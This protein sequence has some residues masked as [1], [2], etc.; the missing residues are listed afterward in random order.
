MTKSF[1][2]LFKKL[3]QNRKIKDGIIT[4]GT[5]INIEK[6]N[7]IIDADLKSESS[8]SIEE[9]KN[10]K[11]Q[12][13]IKISDT[14]DVY[15]EAIE[16]GLGNTILSREKAKKHEAWLIL[17]KSYLNSL[18][19]NGVIIGKVK[20]GFTVNLNNIKAFLPGS[21][22]DIRPIK[23][24]INLEGKELEFKIIKLDKK[25]NNIVISRKAVILN[26]NNN[27]REKLIEN[28]YE[29][30]II[31]G[32]V[33]NITDYG[34]FIDL[35]GLDGLLHITDMA[36]KR[37]KNPRDLLNIGDDIKVKI[38]KF[39]KEKTRVSLGLKQ[40]T[41]D[42][43]TNID[44]K[45]PVNKKIQG[46]ITNLTDYG[47]FIEIEEGIEGLAHISE[48][49]WINKNVN[50]YKI[51]NIEQ[52][53]E[54]II[55][56][57]DKEKRRISLGMKQCT[58]NPWKIFSSKYKKGDKISGKIKSITDF[59]IFLGLKENIDGLVHCTDITWNT[60]NINEQKK[61]YKKGDIIEVSLLQIDIN[62][63][64]ISLGI[65]QLT[66]D[67]LNKFIILNKKKNIFKVKVTEINNNIIKVNLNKNVD[68]EIKISDETNKTNLKYLKKIKVNNFIETKILNVDKKKRIVNLLPVYKENIINKNIKK[69]SLNK[70]NQNC[71]NTMIEAF[72]KAKPE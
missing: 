14:I 70:K 37:I 21:L 28:I 17:E 40:L 19:I 41:K 7:V 30:Y 3:I 48:I 20:G 31:N 62:K 57:I 64:R 38:I 13:E 44:I 68:G 22:V 24:S 39:D 67:P 6:N 23:E 9:F 65:K 1:K 4:K 8:I 53:V 43:W 52:N 16:D 35:G 27:E 29:G 58:P 51:F 5:I 59:G 11:G 55:L 33:K 63:E 47:C 12:L 42:P 46:K 66:E 2:N 36:W 72:K 56:N 50:P 25:R 69:I 49:D 32:I 45:Y 10:I 34:A 15:I 54:A 18:N 26:E 61:K 60:K 71:F